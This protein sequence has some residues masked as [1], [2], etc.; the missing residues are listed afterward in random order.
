MKVLPA[1]QS[2]NLPDAFPLP[3][4]GS[5]STPWTSC[6]PGAHRSFLTDCG[7]KVHNHV[8]YALGLTDQL[9][10]QL[11]PYEFEARPWTL[12][13]PVPTALTASP[14]TRC[15]WWTEVSNR[16]A[17]F[18]RF[19]ICFCHVACH[20]VG[21]LPLATMEASIR[22]SSTQGLTRGATAASH[23]PGSVLSHALPCFEARAAGP[24]CPP[25]CYP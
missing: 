23:C 25:S 11:V 7:V 1:S 6:I 12:R 5:V 20:V 17:G 19:G 4:S 18:V 21:C 16:L 14:P 22:S 13:R 8:H 3:T 9:R 2:T 10:C 15:V 24:V